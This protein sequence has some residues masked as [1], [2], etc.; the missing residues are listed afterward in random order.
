MSVRLGGRSIVPNPA[1][2]SS[3]P[4][5]RLRIYTAYCT[6][7]RYISADFFCLVQLYVHLRTISLS[8]V[9]SARAVYCVLVTL[10]MPLFCTLL[11]FSRRFC[12]GA[13]SGDALPY[14]VSGGLKNVGIV[15]GTL[16]LNFMAK[17]LGTEGTRWDLGSKFFL[18]HPSLERWMRIYTKTC[19]QAA[20]PEHAL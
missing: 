6:I 17:K 8:A 9:Q 19:K 1:E 3:A 16:K 20:T 4:H 10:P 13:F 14:Q 2:F 18:V 12:C 5:W 11:S 7:H 15:S